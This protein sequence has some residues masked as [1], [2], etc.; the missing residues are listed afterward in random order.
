MFD[1]MTRRLHVT[2]EQKA[3]LMALNIALPGGLERWMQIVREAGHPL[4]G[5]V[6][7]FCDEARDA[8]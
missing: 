7:V 3:E 2:P 6:D 5:P 4:D 8:A 1:A